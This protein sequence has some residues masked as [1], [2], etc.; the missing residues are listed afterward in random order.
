MNEYEDPIYNDAKLFALS[1]DNISP[2]SLQR[3]FLIGYNR[4]A[5]LIE[6]MESEGVISAADCTGKRTINK[7]TPT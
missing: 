6:A 4:A 1:R 5:R 3:H 2:A 7:G